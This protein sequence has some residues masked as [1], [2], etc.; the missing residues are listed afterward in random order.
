VITTTSFYN[1]NRCVH[2]NERGIFLPIT[3]SPPNESVNRARALVARMEAKKPAHPVITRANLQVWAEAYEYKYQ[4]FIKQGPSE[5]TLKIAR[6]EK[7]VKS[8]DFKVTNGVFDQPERKVWPCVCGN[9]QE[10][11]VSANLNSGNLY[12]PVLQ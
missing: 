5:G 10:E 9:Q 3:A 2:E 11:G 7:G 4:G 12:A 8:T 6:P 1:L